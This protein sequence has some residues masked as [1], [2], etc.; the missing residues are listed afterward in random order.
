MESSNPKQKIR[1]NE[2]RTIGREEKTFIVAEIGQ[3]HNGEMENAR[4]LID[5]A[6]EAGVDAAKFCKRHIPSE[7][8]EEAYNRPYRGPQSFGETY[9][10]H[11]EFLELTR[12]QHS[13]L[14]E[15]ARGKGLIYFASACD[16]KSVDDM[17]YIGVPL[18][19]VASRDLTNI[20]LIEYMAQTQ[21]P[22]IMST[23]MATERDIEHALKTIYEYHNKVVLLNCTSEYPCDIEHVN[24]N[25]MDTIKETWGTIVG[26]SGHTVGI[27]M[28]TVAVARGAKVVE[29]HITLHRHM[30]GS[31]H[32]ASLE[33]E[34][35]EKVVRDVR[36]TEKCMGDGKIEV[37]EYMKESKKKLARSLVLDKSIKEGEKLTENHLTLKSPGTGIIWRNRGKVVGLKAKDDYSADVLV[38]ENM[39]R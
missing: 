11:R 36:N 10:E 9:G 23:G 6:A 29:K 37:K 24:M 35:L 25:K 32:S 21:K 12:D 7:L 38:E 20:P 18:Y 26:Y 2:N 19:K 39:F 8:T 1:I 3:N 14:A 4:K 34:G 33:P 28:P 31:D 5:V 17:E 30:R 27:Q 13:Q 15:Y 16:R 22:I